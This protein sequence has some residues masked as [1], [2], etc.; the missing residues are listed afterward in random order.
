M[1]GMPTR[2]YR[3]SIQ[4]HICCQSNPAY[5]F[6][7]REVQE[8]HRQQ[9]PPANTP[10]SRIK[11]INMNWDHFVEP[12]CPSRVNSQPE[13][14]DLARLQDKTTCYCTCS[15]RNVWQW[16][17]PHHNLYMLVRTFLSLAPPHHNLQS[18]GPS[19]HPSSYWSSYKSN[20]LVATSN[21][22]ISLDRCTACGAAWKLYLDIW[23]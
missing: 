23:H 9:V 14:M 1:H 16:S 20:I 7:P 15:L 6:A 5:N 13:S 3:G 18:A 22:Y 10:F 4:Y 11:Q 12:K 19:T 17:T 8:V 21:I 2:I